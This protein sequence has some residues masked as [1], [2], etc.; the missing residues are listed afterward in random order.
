MYIYDDLLSSYPGLKPKGHP[1]QVS[2]ERPQADGSSHREYLTNIL[3]AVHPDLVE[4]Y[5][6]FRSYTGL[7]LID[8]VLLM[9]YIYLLFY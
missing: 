6:L 8:I 1:A 2:A 5:Y 9:L 3:I 7:C 4:Y